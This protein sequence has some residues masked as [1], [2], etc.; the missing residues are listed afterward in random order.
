MN[1]II[2]TSDLGEDKDIILQEGFVL[3]EKM[4]ADVELLVIINKNLDY[5]P[6]DIGM[7]FTDQW[8][9][10][11]YMAT[12]EMEHIK[13]K[14]PGV[15]SRVVVFIGDPKEAIIDRAV[16]IKAS[17]IVIGT[18]GRTGLSHLLMGSTAEYVI[19]HSPIPVLVIP[20][21]NYQH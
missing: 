1:T 6:A 4:K 2:I 18:H 7:N 5:I 10:R 19:R 8:E 20:L 16:E 3:A 14:Y 12:T 17:I 15:N 9:A 11:T 21:N 13:S